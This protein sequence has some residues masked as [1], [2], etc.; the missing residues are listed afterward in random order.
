MFCILRKKPFKRDQLPVSKSAPLILVGQ[1]AVFGL[2]KAAFPQDRGSR[3][4]VSV[5]N[6]PY[7]VQI[8]QKSESIDFLN[9]SIHSKP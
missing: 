7:S 1:S 2:F 8:T 3:N 9:E 6:V 5:E 4:T